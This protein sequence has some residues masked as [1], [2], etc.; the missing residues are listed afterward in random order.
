MNNLNNVR[1]FF[2]NYEKR[3]YDAVLGVVKP[4]ADRIINELINETG[5]AF[6]RIVRDFYNDYPVSG[7]QL[8]YRRK[9]DLFKLLKKEK[10]QGKSGLP[11]FAFEFD[12]TQLRYR[13]GYSGEDGLYNT[14]FRQGYHGGSISRRPGFPGGTDTPYYKKYKA[15]KNADDD[16]PDANWSGWSFAAHRSRPPLEAIKEAYSEI[17]ARKNM[18]L[19]QSVNAGLRRIGIS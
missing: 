7:A 5:E 13:S 3:V 14:V 16:S 19:A 8:M 1:A 18:E 2:D 6:N 4:E 15:N 12:E 10:K 17:L 9:Y 11:A